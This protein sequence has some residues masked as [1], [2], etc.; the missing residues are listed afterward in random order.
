[1]RKLEKDFV[2]MFVGFCFGFGFYCLLFFTFAM[3]YFHESKSVRILINEF[4]EA[5][6]E[7]YTLWALLIVMCAFL[8]VGLRRIH[9][10]KKVRC[11]IC[12]KYKSRQHVCND[13]LPF[14]RE[15]LRRKNNQ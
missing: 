1:M 6:V 15:F 14:A 7:W 13:C 10:R 2:I 5:T 8:Y 11:I 3:A 4:G 12:G 9:R